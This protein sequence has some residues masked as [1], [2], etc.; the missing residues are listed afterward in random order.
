MNLLK[1]IAII[2]IIIIHTLITVRNLTQLIKIT[3]VLQNTL[4]CIY[5]GH[6]LCKFQ[7]CKKI[8][9]QVYTKNAKFKVRALALW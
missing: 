2:I 9:A 5:T 3:I 1:I 8:N 7:M 6:V 4:I